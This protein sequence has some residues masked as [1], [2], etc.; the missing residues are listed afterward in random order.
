MVALH[1]GWTYVKDRPSRSDVFERLGRALAGLTGTS[2]LVDVATQIQS[3]SQDLTSTRVVKGAR[4]VTPVG[5]LPENELEAAHLAVISALERAEPD[6][7]LVAG[8]SSDDRLASLL[9]DR[10]FAS[11][12]TTLSEPAST[13]ALRL[14]SACAVFAS[15][16]IR[17]IPQAGAAERAALASLLRQGERAEESHRVLMAS[18]RARSAVD[19]RAEAYAFWCADDL[20]SSLAALK[21]LARRGEWSGQDAYDAGCL[22][23]SQR[24]AREAVDAF[25][26]AV[27]RLPDSRVARRALADA[28]LRLGNFP[29]AGSISQGAMDEL[30]EDAWLSEI[31]AFALAGS[32]GVFGNLWMLTDEPSITRDAVAAALTRTVDLDPDNAPR[33]Y[34]AARLFMHLRLYEVAKVLLARLLDEHPHSHSILLA[35]AICV[36]YGD[37]TNEGERKEDAFKWY[38]RA[39]SESDDF[40]DVEP[41]FYELEGDLRLPRPKVPRFRSLPATLLR[42]PGVAIA[43]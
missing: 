12:L 33:V 30:G 23:M 22:Y 37:A 15:Q 25:A 32:R 19:E 38:D 39:A 2:G 16:E 29:E 20:D 40:I 26:E 42:T 18:F 14:L 43:Y 35:Y 9:N 28:H 6:A 13:Y 1:S 34:R 41:V 17:R 31:Q 10:A 36:E 24:R 27:A 8:L 7:F 21:R 4:R 5:H 3:F 11:E